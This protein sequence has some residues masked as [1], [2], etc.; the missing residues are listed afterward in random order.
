MPFFNSLDSTLGTNWLAVSDF[1]TFLHSK[2]ETEIVCWLEFENSTI[3]YTQEKRDATRN[4]YDKFINWTTFGFSFLLSWCLVVSCKYILRY[5]R[6]W[7]KKRTSMEYEK[8]TSKGFWQGQLVFKLQWNFSV[9]FL[10]F[11]FFFLLLKKNL[12]IHGWLA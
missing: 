11:P 4:S 1:S 3:C 5:N 12:K 7:I 2:K 8:E 10:S 6:N 9:F